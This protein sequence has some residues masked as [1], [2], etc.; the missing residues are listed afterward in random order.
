M[1]ATQQ[2]AQI[3]TSTQLKLVSNVQLTRRSLA[4]PTVSATL[5]PSIVEPRLGVIGLPC[6]A[7]LETMSSGNTQHLGIEKQLLY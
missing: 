3:T 4:W 2:L 6:I 5:I 1:Q 7:S